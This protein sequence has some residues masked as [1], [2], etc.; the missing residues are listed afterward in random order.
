MHRQIVSRFSQRVRY[1]PRRQAQKEKTNIGIRRVRGVESFLSHSSTMNLVIKFLLLTSSIAAGVATEN[2][3]EGTR[4]ITIIRKR[5]NEQP[6]PQKKGYK[7]IKEEHDI[8]LIFPKPT[9]NQPKFKLPHITRD[10]TPIGNKLDKEGYHDYD[11]KY[12]S[13]PRDHDPHGNKD[14]P[15]S[16]H[17]R[18]PHHIPVPEDMSSSMS[19]SLP[20][21]GKGLRRPYSEGNRRPSSK[22][23]SQKSK[24]KYYY[25]KGGNRASGSRF[26]NTVPGVKP[27]GNNYFHLKVGNRVPRSPSPSP[28]PRKGNYY[29][30]KRKGNYYH[31][32]GGNRAQGS[33]SPSPV[34]G[35]ER[36]GN[37]YH[38]EREGNYY[39]HKRG[40]RA[41]ESPSPSPV[42]GAKRKDNYYHD[43]LVSPSPSPSPVPDA[44]GRGKEKGKVSTTRRPRRKGKQDYDHILRRSTYIG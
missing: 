19:Y 13:R 28:V 24:A 42:P 10:E 31:H 18:R 33:P 12:L 1:R 14:Y 16:S 8:D 4:G 41:S 26:P 43:K 5:K 6:L 34:P 17:P 38:H 39:H 27:K 25:H 23:K 44:K 36:K 3:P 20:S 40:N 9:P 7:L 22:T 32:K 11:E 15:R 30:H 29:H 2:Y 37:Y 21:R 35:A